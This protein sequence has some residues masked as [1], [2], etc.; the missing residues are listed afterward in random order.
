MQRE[1]LNHLSFNAQTRRLRHAVEHREGLTTR[2][3]ER[4]G[5]VFL[6]EGCCCGRVDKGFP[7]LPTAMMKESWKRLKLNATIQL[8]ISGCLGPCDVANVVYLLASDGT[9]QWL[10]GLSED[11]QYETLIEWAVECRQAGSL[12]PI[13]A[14]LDCHRFSRFDSVSIAAQT[15]A[16]GAAG[17][18]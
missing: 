3:A 4:L 2:R 5:Q 9:G 15:C 18:P 10:G 7:P 11:W 6:C 12:L 1:S 17:R 13:P 8:T 16:L 14:T